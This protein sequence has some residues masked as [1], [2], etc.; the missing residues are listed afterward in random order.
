MRRYGPKQTWIPWTA[1]CPRWLVWP[2]MAMAGTGGAAGLSVNLHAPGPES[3]D[4]AQPVV[5]GQPRSAQAGQW[6]V[7]HLDRVTLPALLAGAGLEPPPGFK[8]LI[9]RVIRGEEGPKYS[10]YDY[11]GTSLER[12]DWWPASTVKVFA[13]VAALERLRSLGF[14]PRAVITFHYPKGDVHRTVESL[15]RQA[16]THSDNS[17]FDM[18]VE[19]VG[20]DEMNEWLRD[21]GFA[22]TVLLRGY[23][24]RYVDPVTGHGIL[25][26]S[27]PITIREPGRASRRLP[28]RRG[29]LREGCRDLGNCTTLWDLSDCLRRV[30]LH[31]DLRGPQRLA[32]GSDEVKLLRSALSGARERGL[33]VVNGLKAAFPGRAVTCFH[34]PG[35][36]LDWFSDHVFVTIGDPARPEAEWIVA[37][38]ARGGRDALDEA[39]RVVGRLLS[40]GLPVP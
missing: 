21:R 28:E 26:M 23:S 25:R 22:G 2:V 31:E 20:G 24:R 30:M 32:L 29:R 5:T 35:F 37:M 34:K 13:A 18:L 39:A 16:I 40:S 14:T 9:V 38:A 17:A 12:D 4:L 1:G 11:S 36:A 7:D 15:V 8:A 10:L 33:G 3:T 6:S 19:V 27:A